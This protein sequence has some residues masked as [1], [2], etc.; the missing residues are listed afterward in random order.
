MR[1]SQCVTCMSRR[2]TPLK[3]SDWFSPISLFLSHFFLSP[4]FFLISFLFLSLV[5][6]S[7]SFSKGSFLQLRALAAP[8]LRYLIQSSLRDTMNSSII[9][10]QDRGT[11]FGGVADNPYGE[12]M[13]WDFLRD[14]WDEM[15][16][17]GFSMGPLIT[18]VTRRFSTQ[19]KYNEVL[20]FFTANPP[21]GGEMA[22]KV[23][24]IS[25]PIFFFSFLFFSLS[26]L[27][28]FL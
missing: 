25:S 24:R 22:V 11:L 7:I 18:R 15:N 8:K 5:S 2:R 21:N 1:T 14:N 23:L 4:L 20:D 10:S 3:R 26:F 17:R 19:L 13:G 16:R 6:R 27:F 28:S 12:S 9:R